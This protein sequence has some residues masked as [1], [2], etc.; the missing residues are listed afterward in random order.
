M[1]PVTLY[2]GLLAKREKPMDK[3]VV[4]AAKSTGADSDGLNAKAGRRKRTLTALASCSIAFSRQLYYEEQP[5]NNNN[6]QVIQAS[7]GR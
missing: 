6:V 3:K 4:E 1:S 5:K 2:Y 7:V